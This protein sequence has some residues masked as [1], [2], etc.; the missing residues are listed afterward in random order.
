MPK[1]NLPFPMRINPQDK[2]VIIATAQIGTDEGP[3]EHVFLT[4]PT[5]AIARRVL[6]YLA[7]TYR[8]NAL[9]DIAWARY[10]DK[11]T[12]YKNSDIITTYVIQEQNKQKE[13][14]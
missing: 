7:A 11:L 3:T 14:R 2:Y 1:I 10:P 9:P 4:A 8:D 6:A 13:D 12:I 5:K